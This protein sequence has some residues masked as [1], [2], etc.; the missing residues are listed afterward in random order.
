MEKFLNSILEK[1]VGINMKDKHDKYKGVLAYI[2]WYN[3]IIRRD[4]SD[5]GELIRFNNEEIVMHHLVADSGTGES[6]EFKIPWKYV[7]NVKNTG[8]GGL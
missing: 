5:A 4:V 8:Y 1:N 2:T 6:K 7:T 3:P